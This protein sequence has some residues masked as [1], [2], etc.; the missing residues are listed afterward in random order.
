MGRVI[1]TLTLTPACN[2]NKNGDIHLSFG[3]PDP[4]HSRLAESKKII[5]NFLLRTT[6]A[7]SDSGRNCTMKI[8]ENLLRIC[9]CNGQTRSRISWRFTI[10]SQSES[11]PGKYTAYSANSTSYT[12]AFSHCPS[13]SMAC[14]FWFKSKPVAM[15]KRKT[16][17]WHKTLHDGHD[18]KWRAGAGMTSQEVPTENS[19]Q[20]LEMLKPCSLRSN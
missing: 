16:V 17:A 9:S 11:Y 8:S 1:A 3:L 20:K 5:R 13:S 4:S 2:Q 15:I 12:T 19:P 6:L 18:T 14:T 10:R 7:K